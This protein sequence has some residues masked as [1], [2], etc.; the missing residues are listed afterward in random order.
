M[1]SHREGNS[2]QVGQGLRPGTSGS[3][4]IRGPCLLGPSEYCDEGETD[5]EEISFERENASGLCH[6]RATQ[7]PIAGRDVSNEPWATP[8]RWR[9]QPFLI[10]PPRPSLPLGSLGSYGPGFELACRYGGKV[11]GVR[12][13]DHRTVKTFLQTDIWSNY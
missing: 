10:R 2:G 5:R 1:N 6:P 9:R 3:H 11:N 12:S 4:D 7:G 13:I 8:P